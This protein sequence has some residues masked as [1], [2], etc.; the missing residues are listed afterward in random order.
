MPA[1]ED[2]STTLIFVSSHRLWHYE[3]SDDPIFPA[4]SKSPNHPDWW[5]N[6]DRKA[7]PLVCV[8]TTEVCANGKCHPRNSS[9]TTD[10]AWWL[11]KL[12]LEKSNAYEVLE[13]RLGAAL[14]AQQ[15]ISGYFTSGLDPEQWKVEARALFATSLARVQW[16]L[17]SIATGEDVGV[18]GYK[19]YTADQ[20]KGRLCRLYKFRKRGFVN[21]HVAWF[22][23]IIT[24]CSII[25]ILRMPMS[26]VPWS[27]KAGQDQLLV[28]T[29]AGL[30]F[31]GRRRRS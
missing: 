27:H 23:L 13:H 30:C 15:K 20:A 14:L 12:S 4:T 8:D 6:G 5:Y 10:P 7:R 2:G 24:L 18:P 31:C 22:W 17:W 29:L 9:L 26:W 11:M 19:D 21:I 3:P 16:D 28:E 25:C 1:V